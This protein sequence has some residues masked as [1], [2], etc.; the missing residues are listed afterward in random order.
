MRVEPE[1]G[2][3]SM[4]KEFSI[5]FGALNDNFFTVWRPLC[6]ENTSADIRFP[7]T[8]ACGQSFGG[9]LCRTTG[10]PQ[11]QLIALTKNKEQGTKNGKVTPETVQS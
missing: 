10:R 7:V 4:S 2:F 9:G 11:G 6:C 8:E 1:L 3:C 5:T